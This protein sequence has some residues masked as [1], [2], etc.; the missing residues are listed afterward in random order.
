MVHEKLE[1][2][3]GEIRSCKSKKERQDNDQK[4]KDKHWSTRHNTHRILSITI[5][6][7]KPDFMICLLLI[8][9]WP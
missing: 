3:T 2:I 8:W 1:D 5:S 9:N 7:W 6:S 4:I